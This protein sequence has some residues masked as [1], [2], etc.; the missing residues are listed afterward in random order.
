MNTVPTIARCTRRSLRVQAAATLGR[1][2]GQAGHRTALAALVAA[3]VLGI[4]GMHS[5]AIHGTP[6]GFSASPGVPSMAG[7]AAGASDSSRAHASKTDDVGLLTGKVSGD[8]SMQGSGHGSGDGMSMLML[9]AVMLAAA[10]LTVLVLL[11]VGIVRPLLPG[12]FHPAA[13][14]ARALQWVRGTGPPHE[15]H[16]SVIRC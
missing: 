14:R 16:F 5:L 3:L 10:A 1:P 12:A 4:L 9:C 11:V 7:G 2:G 8:G 15:W 6:A 13:V